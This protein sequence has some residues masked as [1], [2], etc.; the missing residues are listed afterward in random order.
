MLVAFASKKEK[1]RKGWLFLVYARFLSSRMPTT[2]MAMII[3][4]A[5]TAVYD[6]IEDSIADSLNGAADDVGQGV[7]DAAFAVI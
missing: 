5:A 1:E 4:I 6:I 7:A 2:A 3:A